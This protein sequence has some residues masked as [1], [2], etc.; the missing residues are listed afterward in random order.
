MSLLDSLILIL[1]AG[2]VLASGFDPRKG[3]VTIL[4]PEAAPSGDYRIVLFGD[5]G[6]ISNN[7]SII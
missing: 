1:A 5:S 2:T 7:F 4:V 3:F 6:N